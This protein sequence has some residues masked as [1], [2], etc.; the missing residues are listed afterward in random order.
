[1]DVIGHYDHDVHIDGGCMFMHAAV[2]RDLPGTS[3]KNPPVI[4][5]ESQKM[6]LVVPLQVWK[7]PSVKSLGHP[8]RA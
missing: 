6:G 1:M 8:G 2:E 3:W 7:V 4:R 5:A